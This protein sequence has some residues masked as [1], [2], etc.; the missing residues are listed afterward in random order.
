MT[1][2]P[3]VT[4]NS[5]TKL[6]KFSNQRGKLAFCNLSGD[7]PISNEPL[8]ESK[9]RHYNSIFNPISEFQEPYQESLYRNPPVYP[10]AHLPP[11][12]PQVS[13]DVRSYDPNLLPP[14][15]APQNPNRFINYFSPNTVSRGIQDAIN[16]WPQP[17]PIPRNTHRVP[18]PQ[19]WHR[20][21]VPYYNLGKPGSPNIP[22]APFKSQD[23]DPNLDLDKTS[24]VQGRHPVPMKHLSFNEDILDATD[25]NISQIFQDDRNGQNAN[26]ISPQIPVLTGISPIRRDPALEQAAQE[27]G[28]KAA[29]TQAQVVAADALIQGAGALGD[30]I[31][32]QGAGP[33]GLQANDTEVTFTKKGSLDLNISDTMLQATSTPLPAS[34]K[35]GSTD[36]IQVP[37]YLHKFCS[38]ILQDWNERFPYSMHA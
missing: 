30:G 23:R 16:R 2:S 26:G 35:S 32:T 12:N 10:P 27:Q 18:L 17:Q 29:Q 25:P 21:P 33:S 24:T 22:R 5:E 9:I 28:K 19:P 38:Q 34:P 20:P 4:D 36:P 14:N 1:F 37:E 13:G 7:P 11:G 6:L 3:P 8:N 15:L 31:Q